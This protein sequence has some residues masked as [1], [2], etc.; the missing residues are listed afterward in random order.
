[1]LLG[2]ITYSTGIIGP[3]L[4][5][6]F[7]FSLFITAV[8][9][10]AARALYF[11]AMQ[12]GNIPLAITGTAVGLVSVVGYTPDIFVGPAM[13]YLLDNSPGITGHQHVFMMVGAFATIGLMASIRL[14]RVTKKESDGIPAKQ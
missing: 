11:A 7:L 6:L 10:Y 8:G 3:S 13:G 2:S 5:F 9:V 4:G 14:H 1:M 12:E